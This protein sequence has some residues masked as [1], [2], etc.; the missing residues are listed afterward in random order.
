MD[1]LRIPNNELMDFQKLLLER[2]SIYSLL[3]MCPRFFVW[4]KSKDDTFNK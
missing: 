2:L 3:L 1:A 4:K